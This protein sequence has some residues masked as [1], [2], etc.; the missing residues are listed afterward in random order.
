MLR[1]PQL[2]VCA[3][4]S[5]N[6]LVLLGGRLELP[7]YDNGIAELGMQLGED[8]GGKFINDCGHSGRVSALVRKDCL[9]DSAIGETAA[10]RS[11]AVGRY[12]MRRYRQ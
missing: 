3:G 7:T 4:F 12:W 6:A 10:L 11:E 9:A 5:R 1:L 2:A 8:V